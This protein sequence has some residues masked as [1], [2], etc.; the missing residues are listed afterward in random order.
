MRLKASAVFALLLGSSLSLAHAQ[1]ADG[2]AAGKAIFDKQCALC[3]NA[4]STEK[5]IGPG[6]KGLYTHG[7]LAD[8]SKVT[9]ELVTERIENGKVPMP[10]FKGTLSP[11]EIKS[12]VQYLKTL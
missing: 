8:G 3:H 7:T 11:D 2:A 4:D 5:K 1:A 10:P 12:V 9:D 6:L